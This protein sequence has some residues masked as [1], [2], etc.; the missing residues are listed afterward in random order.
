M[1][2]PSPVQRE[3]GAIPGCGY[4]DFGAWCLSLTVSMLVAT[5]PTE[6]TG[7]SRRTLVDPTFAAHE[8]GQGLSN[9]LVRAAWNPHR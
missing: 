4:P 5:T 1:G 2:I 3:N 6:A 9:R 7:K 8:R